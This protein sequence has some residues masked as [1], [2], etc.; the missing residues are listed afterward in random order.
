MGTGARCTSSGDRAILPYKLIFVVMHFLGAVAPLTVA[1]VLADVVLFV[2]AAPN[3][4]AM[5]LLTGKVKEMT[6]SY[7]EREPWIENAEV[8]RRL[9]EE[10]RR[11]REERRRR[12]GLRPPCGAPAR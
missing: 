1:W 12:P 2:A 7:F 11:Q 9:M 10:R 8:R 6:D 3:L 5:V 4:I